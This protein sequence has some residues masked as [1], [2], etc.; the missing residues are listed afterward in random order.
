MLWSAVDSVRDA[1][2]ANSAEADRLMTLPA[3]TTAALSASG[4]LALKAPQSLGGAE[5]DLVTQIE[6]IEALASHDSAAA[7]CTMI[8]ASAVGW[9]GAFL[10]DAAVQHL[11]GS[12]RFPWM[13]VVVQPVGRLHEVDGGYRLDGTW[14][15]ASGI[16]HAEW[17]LAGAV[18]CSESSGRRHFVAAIPASAVHIHDDWQSV[19]LQATGSCSFTVADTF[20]PADF[21][22]DFGSGVPQRGGRLFYL[23]WPGF[24]VH[25]PA[26]FMLGL[27]RRALDAVIDEARFVQGRPAPRQANR[28]IFQ[29]SIGAGTMRLRAARSCL[30]ELGTE[31]CAIADSGQTIPLQKQAELRAASVLATEVSRDIVAMAFRAGGSRAVYTKSALPRCLRDAEAAA[32]HWLVRDSAYEMYGRFLLNVPGAHPCGDAP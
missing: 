3:A 19:G 17:V 32:Q 1:V 26:A 18:L 31:L 13:A 9:A 16:R 4:L 25:E 5:A 22:W 8:A 28:Q 24:V 11:F 14:S 2:A 12:A 27:A 21:A 7:W 6:I 20:V 29:H 10:G 30:L 23:G 15:F